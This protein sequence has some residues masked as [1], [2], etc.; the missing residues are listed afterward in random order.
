MKALLLLISV[1]VLTESAMATEWGCYDPK[2]GHPT[3]EEKRNF[4]ERVSS[5]A[6]TAEKKYGVPAPAIAAMTIAESGYGW[7][8]TALEAHNYFGWKYNSAGAA[9]GRGYFVLDC[10][11]AYDVN[12]KY[13]RF[14]DDSDAV[15]FVAS[16]LATLAAYK[17]DTQRYQQ[18]IKSAASPMEASRGWVAG[19]SDPYNWSPAKYARTITRIMNNPLAPSDDVSPQTNLYRLSGRSGAGDQSAA[20]ANTTGDNAVLDQARQAYMSKL[21]SGYRRCEAADNDF[22]RWKG[23]P[24]QRCDYADSGVAVQTY[25]LNPSIEQLAKWTVTAC[26]DANASKMSECV[27]AVAKQVVEASSGVFPVSG[28]IPEHASSGGGEGHQMVCYLFKDGVT[29]NTA[30]YG[31]PP[32]ANAGR[33]PDVDHESAVTRA[34][35]FARV[36][37]TTRGDYRANGGTAPVGTDQDG[38]AQWLDVVRAL[39]QRAWS[40]DRNELIS[41]KAM[42]MHAKHKFE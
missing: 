27:K 6:Q 1:S 15:D 34:K 25:M 40:S 39:Y 32:A 9:G 35:S 7:T 5:L 37:S 30:Q 16:K 3:Q 18:A 42:A 11:P 19:I 28:F 23:F 14:A 38:S 24:V 20:P 36:A 8:R 2:P 12:N 22:P 31:K 29:V 41:A 4:V 10:Q 17:N 21:G 13:I 26:R 33:C